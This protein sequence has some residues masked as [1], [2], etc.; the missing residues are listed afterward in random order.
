MSSRRIELAKG[1]RLATL[2]TMTAAALERLKLTPTAW[3]GWFALQ[4]H[5]YGATGVA[6][7]I[8]ARPEE[9]RA[10]VS[11]ED[12]PTYYA[13]IGIFALLDDTDGPPLKLRQPVRKPLPIPDD[14]DLTLPVSQLKSLYGGSDARYKRLREEAG[15]RIPPGR[16]PS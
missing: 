15:I 7:R 8:K 11:G 12:R 16:L 3:R 13:R 9:V 2:G 4:V 10:W 5:N 14:I 1:N 6:Y